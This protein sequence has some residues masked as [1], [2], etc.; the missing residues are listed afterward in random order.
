MG[1]H[2]KFLELCAISTSGELTGKNRRT[3][4]HTSLNVL[5]AGKH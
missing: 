1:P 3:F 2:D 4:G 5:I